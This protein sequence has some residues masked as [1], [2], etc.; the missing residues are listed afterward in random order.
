[1]NY[2]QPKFQSK[3]ERLELEMASWIYQ[4]HLWK[5]DE[6][7]DGVI[8]CKWCKTRLGGP[9][10]I[11]AKDQLCIENPKVIELREFWIKTTIKGIKEAMIKREGICQE[12]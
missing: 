5:K 9:T 2:D 11:T 7:S 10:C 1:M 8:I 3:E 6:L 12:S 4:S